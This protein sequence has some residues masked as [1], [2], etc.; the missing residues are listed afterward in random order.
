MKKQESNRSDTPWAKG[1]DQNPFRTGKAK[2][3]VTMNFR[4]NSDEIAMNF[5]PM[6]FG[7]V[8]K[9][10][11]LIRGPFF[12]RWSS[13]EIPMKF[14]W[15]PMKS[16]IGLHRNFIG[17]SSMKKRPPLL[18]RMISWRNRTSSAK[19]SSRLRRNFIGSS[20]W[21][22]VWLRQ[23]WRCSDRPFFWRMGRGLMVL[24]V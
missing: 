8:T 16:F 6:K 15:S 23:C 12:H 7:S 21:L 22:A 24:F 1:A 14:R 17:T 5:S 2:P 10:I 20:S 3:Q 13:D 4:W 11:F 18:K 19:S 9:S